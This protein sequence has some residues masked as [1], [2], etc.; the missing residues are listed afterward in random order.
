M[1]ST[2][3]FGGC[4]PWLWWL[5]NPPHLRYHVFCISICQDMRKKFV[6]KTRVQ[7]RCAE[8]GSFPGPE[9]AHPP[10]GKRVCHLKRAP[11]W[12]KDGKGWWTYIDLVGGLVAI[13]GMFPYIGL[14]SSSQLTNSYFSE[15]W[16][17]H[18][19]VILGYLPMS[20]KH[21]GSQKMKSQLTYRHQ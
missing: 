2:I 16:L 13:F 12:D 18:Q 9:V 5:W 17:S 1:W 20:V 8:F 14:L 7:T 6:C 21:S 4:P 15:G 3:I 19:P 10:D 11:R